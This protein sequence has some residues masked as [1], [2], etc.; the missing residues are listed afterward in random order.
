MVPHSGI[1]PKLAALQA[2]V[3]YQF[4]LTGHFYLNKIYTLYS[5]NLDHREPLMFELK[6]SV[7][8]TYSYTYE[9]HLVGL[10]VFAV[11]F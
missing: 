3:L 1:E 7:I 2:I 11:L 10:D 9:S 8:E 4:T 5:V 6:V